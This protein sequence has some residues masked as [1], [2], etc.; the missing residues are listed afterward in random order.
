MLKGED[1]RWFRNGNIF[2][3]SDEM[4]QIPVYDQI[5]LF[6]RSDL[7]RLLSTGF[8]YPTPEIFKIFQKGEFLDE[9]MYDISSITRLNKIMAEHAEHVK[10]DMKGMTLAELEIKFTQTFDSGI[11]VP[12]CPL[13]EGVYSGKPRSM[14][15][16]DVSEFYNYFGLRMSRE[17]GKREFPDHICAELEFLHFL[18]YNEASSS[19]DEETLKG[20]LLAHRDFLERHMV[21]WVP[22]F[23]LRLQNSAGL[24]FYA[25]L[26][27]ITSQLITCELEMLNEVLQEFNC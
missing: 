18:T 8:R 2:L 10:D 6:A 27:Q 26:A 21:Q 22:E 3:S 25:W 19:G 1:T 14:I 15:M 11:P 7:H 16:L 9:I 17:E 4:S 24:P 12:P 5:D 20:Y 13:Y 23:C